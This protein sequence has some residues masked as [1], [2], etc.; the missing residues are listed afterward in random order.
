MS[1]TETLA[2]FAGALAS[3][4]IRV[5]D[6]TQPLGPDT[7]ILALPPEFGKNSSPVKIENISEF[8]E[9]GQG[10]Y[11][12]NITMGEHTGTHF[13]APVHWITGK[14][15]PDGATDTIPA[16]KLV[17][18]ACV[19]DCREEVADDPDFLVT[20]DYVK[21]WEAKNGDIPAGSWVLMCSGWW[22]RKG[23]EEFLNADETGP[24]SPGPSQDCVEYLIHERDVLGWGVDTVGTDAG[25]AGMFEVPF[26]AHTLMHGANKLGLAS[27]AN[28]DQLPPTGA[29]LITPP[30]KLVRGSGSPLRVLALVAA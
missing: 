21:A 5:V 25:Q 24:H 14:D 9:N 12:N 3:G 22:A 27:L 7:P 4:D 10:W 11:W 17:A 30:L 26:P 15:Y 2:T 20:A 18:P 19:L 29:V 13:D 8:D 1:G 28:L 16:E 6:L 23:T